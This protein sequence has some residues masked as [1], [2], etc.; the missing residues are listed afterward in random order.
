MDI[1]TFMYSVADLYFDSFQAR[2]A[3]KFPKCVNKGPKKMYTPQ[4]FYVQLNAPERNQNKGKM[5][6][7]NRS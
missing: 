6:F 1:L 2:L 4:N 5:P 7:I 3:S